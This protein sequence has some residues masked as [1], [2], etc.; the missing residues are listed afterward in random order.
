MTESTTTTTKKK[1]RHQTDETEQEKHRG[2]KSMQVNASLDNGEPAADVHIRVPP[3]VLS[4]QTRF[5]V[6]QHD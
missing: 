2:T 3:V 6:Q 1:S 5:Q 4:H